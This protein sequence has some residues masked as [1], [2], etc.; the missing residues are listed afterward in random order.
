MSNNHCP[1]CGAE[2]PVTRGVKI[3]IASVCAAAKRYQKAVDGSYPPEEIAKRLKGL[4]EAKGK[5][6][7]EVFAPAFGQW[8]SVEEQLPEFGQ[9]VLVAH[10]TGW[11]GMASLF[12]DGWFNISF[13]NDKNSVT[14][15]MPLPEP[16][17]EVEA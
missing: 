9:E 14:H 16:P 1:N 10:D 7:N 2:L 3:C 8:I 17:E 6:W 13:H 15:W 12:D 4:D 5:L 11:I